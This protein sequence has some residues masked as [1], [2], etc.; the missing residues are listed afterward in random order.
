MAQGT[1]LG[2]LLQTNCSEAFLAKLGKENCYIHRRGRREEH[3]LP[4]LT[5]LHAGR[6]GTGRKVSS[7]PSWRAPWSASGVAPGGSCQGSFWIWTV[8]VWPCTDLETMQRSVPVFPDSM[9]NSSMSLKGKEWKCAC[10]GSLVAS[11]FPEQLTGNFMEPV[12]NTN[13]Q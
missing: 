1:G 11:S 4:D 5:Q 10:V 2:L 8:V 13:L 12:G 3:R 9:G 7:L 6:L